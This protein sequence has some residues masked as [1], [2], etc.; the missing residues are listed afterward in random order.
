MPTGSGQAQTEHPALDQPPVGTQGT[1][2]LDQP[3]V[4]T[5]GTTV[6]YA[7]WL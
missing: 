3:P 2:V 1:T 6:L 4:G 5:Q 7:T